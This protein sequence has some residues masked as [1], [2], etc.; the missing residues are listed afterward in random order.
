MSGLGS[1]Y[2]QRHKPRKLVYLE[3]HDDFQQARTR[4]RQ[5]KGWRQEKKRKLIKGEWGKW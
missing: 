3:E 5:I 4:E 1:K 2:T